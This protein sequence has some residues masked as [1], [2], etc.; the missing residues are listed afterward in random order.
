MKSV[1]P[2][3]YIAVAVV[4]VGLMSVPSI[5]ANHDPKKGPAKLGR[6]EF[7]EQDIKKA[8]DECEDGGKP[9]PEY[10]P[11]VRDKEPNLALLKDAQPKVSSTIAGWCPR[12]HCFRVP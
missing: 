8:D 6:Y 3:F 4:L 11:T 1:K 12:R 2:V 5:W 10:V 7:K 9:G